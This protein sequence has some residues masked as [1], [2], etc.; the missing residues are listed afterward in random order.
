MQFIGD[1]YEGA[2]YEH[3]YL[4][5]AAVPPAAAAAAAS[6]KKKASTK[7]SK[8]DGDEE[9]GK[10]GKKFSKPGQRRETPDEVRCTV[11][12]SCVTRSVSA[13]ESHSHVLRESVQGETHVGNGLRTHL[14]RFLSKRECAQSAK[15]LLQ[16]G[17][18][19]HETAEKVYKKFV[20]LQYHVAV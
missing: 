15:W 2:Q 9:E 12:A 19:D 18:F 4:I 6:G 1:V 20:S 13:V 11:L 14:Q 16:H 3:P 17:V 5:T 10:K 8:K 7:S